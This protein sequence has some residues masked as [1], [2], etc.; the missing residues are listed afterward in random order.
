MDCL[1][2]WGRGHSTHITFTCT[3]NSYLLLYSVI[4]ANALPTCKQY[5]IRRADAT[6][7]LPNKQKN[8]QCVP[9]CTLGS[10]TPQFICVCAQDHMLFTCTRPPVSQPAGSV[11]QLRSGQMTCFLSSSVRESCSLAFLK[12]NHE[13]KL[14]LSF[15]SFF[16]HSLT[17]SLNTLMLT[18]AWPVLLKCQH[19]Y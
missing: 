14:S 7:T 15:H 9:R 12:L 13:S 18:D 16:T 1:S 10:G 2:V 3:L 17:H 19:L 8:T 6:V 5:F 11:A 4:I